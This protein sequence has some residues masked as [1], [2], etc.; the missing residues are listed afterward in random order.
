ME[1]EIRL[2]QLGSR[3][4]A[5]VRRCAARHELSKVVPD[6]CGTVWNVRR[7]QQIKGAGRHVAVYLDDRIN[8]EIGVELD[9]PF[10][11]AGGAVNSA[12]P[13]RPGCDDDSLWAIRT[14]PSGT[15]CDSPMVQEEWQHAGRPKLGGVWPLDR[16]VQPRP[17]KNRRSRSYVACCRT[18]VRPPKLNERDSLQVDLLS[19]ES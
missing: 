14:T 7:S 1:Y 9:A 19:G 8:L 17:V 12:T 3:P 18:N 6:A 2:E 16:R 13:G 4:L 15:R 5:V 11:G 10:V